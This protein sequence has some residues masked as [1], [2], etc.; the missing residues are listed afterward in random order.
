[1]RSS[2][3]L[4]AGIPRAAAW[5]RDLLNPIVTDMALTHA[6]RASYRSYADT[7]RY[8]P[9]KHMHTPPSAIKRIRH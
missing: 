5:P 9:S 1:V 4:P 6:D 7:E 8:Q 2:S 3:V